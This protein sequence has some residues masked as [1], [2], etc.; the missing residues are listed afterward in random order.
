[1]AESNID[2]PVK[3]LKKLGTTMQAWL[4]IFVTDR[5]ALDR[6]NLKHFRQYRGTYDPDVLERIPDTRSKA[7]PRHSRTKVRNSVASMLNMAHPISDKNWGLE[8]SPN[9]EIPEEDL[10]KI[11]A[12][13]QEEAVA[14]GV[15]TV[16]SEDIE[17]RV[18]EFAEG[19]KDNMEREISDQLTDS[20]ADIVQLDRRV[21][22][23]GHVYGYGVVKCPVVRTVKERSW[24]PDASGGYSPVMT[25][26]RKPYPVFVKIWDIYPDLSAKT[27]ADQDM[28]FERNVIARADLRKLADRQDFEKAN[29]LDYLKEHPKGNYQPHQYESVINEIEESEAVSRAG[30]KYEIYRALG[31]VSAHELK[32]A[33]LNLADEEMSE[34]IFVD[35]WFIDDVIIKA[36]R[37]AFGE[38]PSDQYHAYIYSEDD[39]AGLTGIGMIEDIRDSQMALCA[40]TRALYDNMAACSGPIYEVNR[41]VLSRGRKGLGPIHP[42]MTIEKEAV[43]AD[44]QA[45]AIIAVHSDSHIA[46]ILQVLSQAKELMDVESNIP[47]FVHGNEVQKMGEAFRT[48]TNMSMAFSGAAT[49]TKDMVRAYDRYVASMIG[50]MLKWNMEFNPKKNIKGDFSVVTKGSQSQVAKE[51]RGAALDQF[52]ATL[53]QEDRAVLDMYGITID[54]LKARDLPLDRVLPKEEAMQALAQ[55]RQANAQDK[56]IEQDLTV[57]K[58][59]NSM[60]S[61]EKQK[62]DAQVMQAS[63]DA[64]IKEIISRIEVNMSQVKDASDR[65]Q[66]ENLKMLLLSANKQGVT[67]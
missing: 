18:R 45:R 67:K 43:G 49:V 12:E 48:T 1:M 54:R 4:K 51:T 31:R 42:F 59:Q 34:D 37:A 28:I 47:S 50:S 2:V 58:T 6:K 53:N 38:K 11:I 3:D 41:S 39:D 46:E 40:S 21:M 56:K 29:I 60:A 64:T 65:T 36:R 17:K 52:V 24:K 14:A 33:G 62:V 57:A 44:A 8:I 16:K 26:V 55:L 20:H 63:A 19:R 66:L 30:R 7:Y 61:A 5:Q 23:S 32:D 9:P 22:H 13:L 15:D 10:E 35:I 27:W 25:T